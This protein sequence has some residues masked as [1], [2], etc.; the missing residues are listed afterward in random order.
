MPSRFMQSL[1][2]IKEMRDEVTYHTENECEFCM[3][4]IEESTVHISSELLADHDLFVQTYPFLPNPIGTGFYGNLYAAFTLVYEIENI[5]DQIEYDGMN[6]TCTE[7]LVVLCSMLSVNS[8]HAMIDIDDVFSFDKKYSLAK[9]IYIMAKN[10]CD[11]MR[12]VHAVS[13][14]AIPNDKVIPIT[15]Y[16]EIYRRLCCKYI[17][18]GIAVLKLFHVLAVLQI[19]PLYNDDVHSIAKKLIGILREVLF[20]KRIVRMVVDSDTH[21]LNPKAHKTT[22]LK[23][24]F[25]MGNSD[26]YCIRLDF[27]HQGEDSIH[28][29]MNEPESN[30]STGFPFNISK[31]EEAIK[32]CGDKENFDCLFYFRDDLYWF[33]S[34]FAAQLKEIEKTDRERGQALD[35]FYHDRAHL[36]V[37]PSNR[38]N[39]EA[40]SRFSEAL[41]EAFVDYEGICIY[42]R[43][44][45][46]DNEFYKYILFQDR[47]FELVLSFSTYRIK[48]VIKDLT[49][50]QT[51]KMLELDSELKTKLCKHI[52][53]EFPYDEGLL[54]CAN[55]PTVFCD[56]LSR[57]LDCLDQ[58]GI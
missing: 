36:E 42:G 40:V 6:L 37:F 51:D 24:F 56:F 9:D 35:R 22:R 55:Q 26:R 2:F 27:P 8:T 5:L 15:D 7:S 54:N 20:D 41:A 10:M 48:N 43:T 14:R 17:R 49:I 18:N 52:E 57:C 4:Y 30:Q 11:S 19:S 50:P 28:L 29:N 53:K 16:D 23:V 45:S 21:G 13:E 47:I 46:V 39:M 33:R 25:A 3:K 44:D 1:G 32:I 12:A 38:E 34:G 58:K 31:Y